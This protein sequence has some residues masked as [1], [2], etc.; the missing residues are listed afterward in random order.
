MYQDYDRA[1][2]KVIEYLTE[3]NYAFS[4]VYMNKCQ[5]RIQM[6]RFRQSRMS[7]FCCSRRHSLFLW[8]SFVGDRGS[9]PEKTAPRILR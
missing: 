5:R 4:V 1:A 3:N 8:S 9:M 7:I 6:S 2:G